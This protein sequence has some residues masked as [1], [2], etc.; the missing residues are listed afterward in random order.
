MAATVPTMSVYTEAGEDTV[1]I[2]ELKLWS[3]VP[4]KQ[5]TGA[6]RDAVSLTLRFELALDFRG[7]KSAARPP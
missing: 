7:P 5:A 2:L 3:S 4:Q 1:A 6:E